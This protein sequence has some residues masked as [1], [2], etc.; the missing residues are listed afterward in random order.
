MQQNLPHIITKL[1]NNNI[2]NIPT[3]I[4][5]HQINLYLVINGHYHIIGLF[6]VQSYV[7]G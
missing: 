5:Q 7:F 2:K 4:N 3:S 1:A 6:S